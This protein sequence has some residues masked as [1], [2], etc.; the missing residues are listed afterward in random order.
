MAVSVYIKEEYARPVT[1]DMVPSMC[2]I[3]DS[4]GDVVKTL[5][6]ALFDFF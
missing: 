6:G 3:A 2:G 5:I 4:D 1:L